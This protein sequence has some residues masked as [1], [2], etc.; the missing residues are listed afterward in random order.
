MGSSLG[1]P[2]L[3]SCR[4]KSRG[5]LTRV[6][7]AGGRFGITLCGL[8]RKQHSP[9]LLRAPPLP[10]LLPGAAHPLADGAGALI[11]RQNALARGGN[12]PGRGNQLLGILQRSESVQQAAS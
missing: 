5:R 12:G 9:W 4:Q 8:H 7:S 2:M 6:Q 10:A 1:H 3:A 11:C